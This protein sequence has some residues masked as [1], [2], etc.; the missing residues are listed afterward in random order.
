MIMKTHRQLA[1]L[2]VALLAFATFTS[3]SAHAA[4]VLFV[5]GPVTPSLTDSNIITRLQNF[6]NTVTYV[7]SA[8]STTASAAGQNAVIISSTVP[9]GEVTNKFADVT[10]GVFNWEQALQQ[11]SRMN[12]LTEAAERNSD[13]AFTQL[14]ITP[15]GA[16]SPLAAGLAPGLYSV[17]N[18][19]AGFT[20]GNSVGFGAGATGVALRGD[21]SGLEANR[22][23]IYGYEAGAIRPDGTASPGR[24]VQFF[25]NDNSFDSLNATGLQLFD[26]AASYVGAA[27]PEPSI[28]ALAGI[29]LAALLGSRKRRVRS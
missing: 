25:L 5:G 13:G 11:Q 29:G 14:T 3:H 22:F 21:G 20:Y 6:G 8:A 18:V 23:G 16:S 4:A 12:F 26:A 17:T 27:V 28:G 9:S 19:A 2:S 24:R 7:N 15:G 10:I 1:S